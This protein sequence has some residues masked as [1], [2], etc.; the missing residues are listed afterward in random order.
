MYKV[1]ASVWVAAPCEEVFAFYCEPENW[2]PTLP[3]L[4]ALE[5][6]TD[7]PFGLGTRWRQRRRFLGMVE[8]TWLEVVE[9]KPP[10][11]IEIRVHLEKVDLAGVTIHVAH[12]MQ[13]E[14][15]GTRWFVGVSIERPR[16][17]PRIV[18]WLALVPMRWSARGDLAKFKAAIQRAAR[19]PA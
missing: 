12:H 16:P 4:L 3:S 18:E 2:R 19:A 14:A 17:L 7:P 1:L 10:H 6:L 9:F 13:G 15:G 5:T 11:E 8:D